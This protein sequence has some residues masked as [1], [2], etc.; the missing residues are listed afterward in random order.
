[1]HFNYFSVDE[2]ESPFTA[3]ENALFEKR[4]TEG[5][6]LTTDHR[7]NQWLQACHP[8][9]AILAHIPQMSQGTLV[10]FTARMTTFARSQQSVGRLSHFSQPLTNEQL[11]VAKKQ[12]G[13]T[14][15][16]WNM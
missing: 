9:A 2:Q 11:V 3:A 8:D 4:Y 14:R 13:S 12:K 6:D 10:P 7:Y 15:G 5:Y 1:M 16:R